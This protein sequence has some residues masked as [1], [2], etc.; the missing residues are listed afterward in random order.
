MFFV[1]ASC[2]YALVIIIIHH[3]YAHYTSYIAILSTQ[4]CMQSTDV[5]IGKLE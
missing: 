2:S 4:K 5:S 3:K 1:L